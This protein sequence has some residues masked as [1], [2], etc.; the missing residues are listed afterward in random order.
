MILKIGIAQNTKTGN[1]ERSAETKSYVEQNS[2]FDFE[3]W[4][5]SMDLFVFHCKDKYI[6]IKPRGQVR[7]AHSCDNTL[8]S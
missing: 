3:T 2:K 8:I 6:G 7:L 5:T 4:L 1:D